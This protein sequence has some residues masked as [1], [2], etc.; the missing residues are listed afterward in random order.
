MGFAGSGLPNGPGGQDQPEGGMPPVPPVPALVDVLLP[1][2]LLPVLAPPPR[3]VLLMELRLTAA[4]PEPPEPSERV[5]LPP[6]P[7]EQSPKRLIT[8]AQQCTPLDIA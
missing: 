5:P 7:Q 1:P 3:P 8:R 6:P 4:P 2:V